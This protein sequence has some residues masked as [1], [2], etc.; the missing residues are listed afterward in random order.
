MQKGM[1]LTLAV[2]PI[3]YVGYQLASGSDDNMFGRLYQNFKEGKK[4]TV[5]ADALHT[6]VLS[7]AISDRARL[8][9][10]PRDTGGPG[11]MNLE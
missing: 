11:V 7:Q 8:S 3:F 5:D 2:V 6:A 4:A 9:S 10:Y 1:Y